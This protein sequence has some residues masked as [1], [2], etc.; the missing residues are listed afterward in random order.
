MRRLCGFLP[1][2]DKLI[3]SRNVLSKSIQV[4]KKIRILHNDQICQFLCK[5]VDRSV[6]R[7]VGLELMRDD[8]VLNSH[9]FNGF[10]KN[11]VFNMFIKPKL[12]TIKYNVINIKKIKHIL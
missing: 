1:S 11:R 4:K 5:I 3:W 9:I 10:D 2:E 7:L 8:H 6:R 12:K